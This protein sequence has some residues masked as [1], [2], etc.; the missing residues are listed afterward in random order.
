MKK[1]IISNWL[2]LVNIPPFLQAVREG[3]SERRVEVCLYLL[4][5]TG[6]SLKKYDIEALKRLQVI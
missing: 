4:A 3:E 6:H 2:R 1:I 5:P